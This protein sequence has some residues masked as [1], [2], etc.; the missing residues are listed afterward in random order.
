MMSAS[1]VAFFWILHRRNPD[2]N[3]TNGMSWRTQAQRP[4]IGIIGYLTGIT[5]SFLVHPALGLTVLAIP[6]YYRSTAV[7]DHRARAHRG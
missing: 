6:V 1:W 4:V 7:R 2:T 5:L 3:P